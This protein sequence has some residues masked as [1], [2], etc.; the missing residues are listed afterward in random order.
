MRKKESSSIRYWRK[1]LFV[2]VIVVFMLLGSSVYFNAAPALA[3][4][5]AKAVDSM[6]PDRETT[7]G[8][9]IGSLNRMTNTFSW[10]GIPYAKPPV[11]DLRWKAPQEPE[12]RSTPFE[13]VNFCEICPQYTDHDNNPVTPQV[14]KGKEDCLYLNIWRPR[15]RAAAKRAP[16]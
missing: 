2:V 10:K 3:Q 12:K 16:S 14:I 4:G 7:E 9:V 13:A 6:R 8:A 15:S 1:Q 5:R 11:G